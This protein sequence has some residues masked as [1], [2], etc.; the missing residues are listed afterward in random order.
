MANPMSNDTK[1]S[2]Q[3]WFNGLEI[4]YQL[5]HSEGPVTSCSHGVTQGSLLLDNLPHHR[6]ILPDCTNR[7]C[8]ASRACCQ[9]IA[10]LTRPSHC[11]RS[12]SHPKEGS[13]LSMVFRRNTFVFSTYSI[14]KSAVQ[15]L[16]VLDTGLILHIPQSH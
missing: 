13:P 8:I 15:R 1:I 7:S 3:A 5:G 2:N 4:S 6:K 14:A 9:R 10:L 16:L 11:T 12:L